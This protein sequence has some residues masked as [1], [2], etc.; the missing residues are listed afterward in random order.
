MSEDQ[1]II[2]Q[3]EEHTTE[4]QPGLLLAAFLHLTGFNEIHFETD[5]YSEEEFTLTY[6]E[7]GS[8]DFFR[9]YALSGVL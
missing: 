4:T 2:T 9:V 3:E 5:D 8:V 6:Q 7:G 1:P